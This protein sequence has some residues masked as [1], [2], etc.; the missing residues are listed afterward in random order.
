M[1]VLKALV[2]SCICGTIF[3]DPTDTV[4]Q[5]SEESSPTTD[6]LSKSLFYF[7]FVSLGLALFYFFGIKR[8]D[9]TDTISVANLNKHVE[10]TEA[11][12]STGSTV[13]VE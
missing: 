1:N 13:L 7:F 8:L 4:P 5:I 2:I 11:G 9:G 3:S 10:D 12:K 6:S